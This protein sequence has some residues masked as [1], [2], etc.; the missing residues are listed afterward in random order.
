MKTL[1]LTTASGFALLAAAACD[2]MQ[3]DTVAERDDMGG[4]EQTDD[5]AENRDYAENDTG[6]GY[7]D[8]NDTMDS[9]DMDDTAEMGD[10]NMSEDYDLY[11]LAMDEYRATNLIGAQVFGPS[12]EEIATIADVK[13]DLFSGD[14]TAIILRDG[15]TL[16]LGGELVQLSPDRATINWSED[17]EANAFINLDE[18]ALESLASFEQDG[19]NDYSLASELIGTE[20][21]L[22]G[23]DQSVR[24]F[25]IV[26][27]KDG[28]AE[29]IAVTDGIEGR[30]ADT[31]AV[32]PFDTLQVAQ[33]DGDGAVTLETDMPTIES[34]ERIEKDRG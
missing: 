10:E 28:S 4:Y 6:M 34:A 13:L 3:D 1:I 2:G 20:A 16:G 15:G 14:A 29:W 7:G 33:G 32:I 24:I 8:E 12:G 26:M 11:E 5:T 31:A 19:M 18:D 22:A 9:G 23:T 27:T 21:D 17:G 30:F 25:D